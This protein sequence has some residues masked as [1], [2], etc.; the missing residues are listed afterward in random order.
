MKTSVLNKIMKNLIFPDRFTKKGRLAY[1]IVSHKTGLMVLVGL[2]L[3]N[4]IDSTSFLVYYF[5]QCLYEPFNALNFSLGGRIGTYWSIDSTPELQKR[6]NDFDV[7]N[8]LNTFD[9]FLYF[10]SNHPFYGDKL[11]RDNYLT[12]TYFIFSQYDKSLFY[13]NEIISTE[14]DDNF[15]SYSQEVKNAQ[16]IKNFIINKNYDKGILQLL[17]WQSQTIKDIGLKIK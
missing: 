2:C 7:L 5:A 14:K 8:K 15:S 12:L 11:G 13:L 10:L 1:Y 17:Q 4:S 3:D 9:D 16:L 6:I